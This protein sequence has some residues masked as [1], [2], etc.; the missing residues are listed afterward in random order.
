MLMCLSLVVPSVSSLAAVHQRPRDAA[1][2]FACRGR[3]A[4]T[5]TRS[6]WGLSFLVDLVVETHDRLAQQQSRDKRAPRRCP[7]ID[8]SICPGEAMVKLPMY[9]RRA[10]IPG[11][12]KGERG[13]KGLEM[14]LGSISTGKVSR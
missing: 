5:P 1:V 12:N 14:P 11:K 4:A 3:C 9:P 13:V 6:L 8:I 10:A 7:G 2:P